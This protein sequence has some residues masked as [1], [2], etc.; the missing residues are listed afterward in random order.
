MRNP[1]LR[2]PAKLVEALAVLPQ[3]KRA[4]PEA[5]LPFERPAVLGAM[6]VSVLVFPVLKLLLFARH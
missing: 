5:R 2:G 3:V 4:L 1:V 6:V